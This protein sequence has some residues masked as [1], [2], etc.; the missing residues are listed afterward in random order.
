M[1]WGARWALLYTLADSEKPRVQR[2]P[3]QAALAAAYNFFYRF[4]PVI[5]GSAVGRK[6]GGRG[7]FQVRWKPVC[8][9]F[10]LRR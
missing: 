2:S 9:M 7:N 3:L 8:T 5:A 6:S 10:Q 4:V 1:P